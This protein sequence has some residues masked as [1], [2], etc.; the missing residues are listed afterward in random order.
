[1]IET[2]Q[3]RYFIA[4]ADELHF[5]RAAELLHM[6][7][8]PLSQAVRALEQQVGARLL[9]RN[10]R[11]VTLTEAGRAFLKECRVLVADAERAHAAAA[12]AA[13]GTT[14][15]LWLGA[16]TSAFG[17]P[18]PVVLDRF[19]RHRPGA[20]L[21]VSEIDTHDG[22][23]AVRSGELDVALVRQVPSDTRLRTR[24]LRRDHLVVALPAGHP[25]AVD[26][27]RRIDLAVLAD[28]D[29]VWLPRRISP[30]YHDELVA[31]CR[32]CGFS[33]RATHTATSIASQLAMVRCGLGVTLVPNV[34]T[35][36]HRA[37]IRYREPRRHLE[38]V[39]LSLLWRS[40]DSAP[41][42][43]AFIECATGE[44]GTSRRR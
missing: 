10:S 38:L 34:V 32:A 39:E 20:V 1:M 21:R 18:L 7:Q 15:T 6:S 19:R 40:G 9:D 16:V 14:G 27:R 41:L 31:A 23:D 24:P 28:E 5:G 29:W 11:C 13:A 37:G 36:D 43:H 25:R 42:L 8:P 26:T 30:D 35:G 3:A 4:V 2:R 44:V 12:L 22:R 17:D 33:P